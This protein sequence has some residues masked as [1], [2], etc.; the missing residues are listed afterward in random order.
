MVLKLKVAGTLISTWVNV[1][2]YMYILYIYIWKNALLQL[3]CIRLHLY[4]VP[5]AAFCGP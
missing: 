2:V 4:Q 3:L 5:A 1:C